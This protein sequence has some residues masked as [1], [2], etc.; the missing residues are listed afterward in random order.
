MYSKNTYLFAKIFLAVY[1]MTILGGC[2]QKIPGTDGHNKKKE[3]VI[4][5]AEES[6]NFKEQLLHGIE[7]FLLEH[8]NKSMQINIMVADLP[9]QAM[10]ADILITYYSYAM[11]FL[12]YTGEIIFLDT[13]L[14]VENFG[15][16]AGEKIRED[17]ELRDAEDYQIYWLGSNLPNERD[18][19]LFNEINK[20]FLMEKSNIEQ[21]MDSFSKK[22]E[23]A[24][25]LEQHQGIIAVVGADLQTVEWLYECAIDAGRQY[26]LSIFS[27]E[28]S[29]EVEQMIRRTMVYGTVLEDPQAIGRE[30][31]YRLLENAPREFFGGWQIVCRDNLDFPE[32]KQLREFQK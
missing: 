3:V 15:Q 4:Y 31:G 10:Q 7:S 21:I 32:I 23:I 5:L 6:T 1:M 11:L 25:W 14:N 30:I 13:L 24:L 27:L 20:G 16:K 28:Y 17:V 19:Q 9:S 2:V 26:Q 12:D 29:G 8:N 22:E 18:K